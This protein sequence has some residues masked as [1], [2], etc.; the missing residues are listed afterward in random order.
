M[1]KVDTIAGVL[2]LI[3]AFNWGLV[4]L[5]DYDLIDALV[6]PIWVVRLFYSLVGLAAIYM[7][8]NWKTI[9]HRWKS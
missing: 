7:T 5:F 3:G 9:R 2:I 4:G 6:M 8:V 1:K